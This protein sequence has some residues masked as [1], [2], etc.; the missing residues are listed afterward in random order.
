M[1]QYSQLDLIFIYVDYN[2]LGP[3][4]AHQLRLIR[5]IR[6]LNELDCDFRVSLGG[7][8]K[9]ILSNITDIIEE[10]LPHERM[11]DHFKDPEAAK[12]CIPKTVTFCEERKN[13][14]Y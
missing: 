9:Q 11:K 6:I 10:F 8:E 7:T 2:H 5:L 14:L 1:F 13:I 4:V 12:Q 3:I